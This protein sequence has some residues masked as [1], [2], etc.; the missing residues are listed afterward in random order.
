[1]SIWVSPILREYLSQLADVY[2]L[3]E[4]DH[5]QM[6]DL[7]FAIPNAADQV[8]HVRTAII[9][10]QQEHILLCQDQRTPEYYFL[11]G[12]AVEAGEPSLAAAKREWYEETGLMV[13][14]LV[15]TAILESFFELKNKAWHE[16]AFYYRVQKINM[17]IEA[18]QCLDNKHVVLKWLPINQLKHHTVYP[19]ALKELLEIPMGQVRH[20]VT[21]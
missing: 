9:C 5:S 1:M 7:R 2:Q 14:D 10:V 16:I 20:L 3:D 13:S 8:L 18:L 19:K 4:V 21:D 17:K 11:P 6:A 12:G 15:L